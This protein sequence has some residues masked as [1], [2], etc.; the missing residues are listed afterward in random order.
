MDEIA[1]KEAIDRHDATSQSISITE[2]GKPW[3]ALSLGVNRSPSGSA[4]QWGM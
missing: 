2:H 1:L 3:D 4:Q